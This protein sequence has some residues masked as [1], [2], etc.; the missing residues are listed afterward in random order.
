MPTANNRFGNRLADGINFG[1]CFQYQQQ[2]QQDII[3]LAFSCYLQLWF[4]NRLWYRA[5][6]YKIPAHRLNVGCNCDPANFKLDCKK[7]TLEK[8]NIIIYGRGKSSYISN[9]N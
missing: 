9:R 7:L 6:N 3:N 5:D 4:F 1:I 8:L 2:F